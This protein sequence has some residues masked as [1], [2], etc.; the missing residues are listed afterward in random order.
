MW[1]ACYST[2][3][4]R[5]R[6]GASTTSWSEW[7]PA[8]A[9][10]RPTSTRGSPTRNAPLGRGCSRV[11]PTSAYVLVCSCSQTFSGGQGFRGREPELG[12]NQVFLTAAA[13]HDPVFRGFPADLEVCEWHSNHFSLPPGAVRLARSPRYEN[14]AIRYGRV[15]YGIQSHLETSL[16][17]L[18]VWL[19]DEFPEL[20]IHFAPLTGQPRGS[21]RAAQPLNP[22]VGDAWPPQA[23]SRGRAATSCRPAHQLRSAVPNRAASGAVLTGE[24]CAS[25][26]PPANR[27]SEVDSQLPGNGGD[28]V[29]VHV[30]RPGLDRRRPR[31]WRSEPAPPASGSCARRWLCRASARTAR[32]RQRAEGDPP[33]DGSRA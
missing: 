5:Y 12:V 3:A 27:G 18:H 7:A 28:L 15:A 29:S 11:A 20:A 16:E 1:I 33:P 24:S 17:N 26:W 19:E 2:R 31:A 9:S 30:P 10:G 8:S 23:P 4:S 25:P 6:T 32:P 22:L 13:Q 21:Q 14:Q